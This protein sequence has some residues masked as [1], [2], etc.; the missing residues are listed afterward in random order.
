MDIKDDIKQAMKEKGITTIKELSVI[1]GISQACLYS[2]LNK[3]NT[4]MSRVTA[5]KLNSKLN[6]KLEIATKNNKKENNLIK[7]AMQKNG[8]ETVKEL[9]ILTGLS[10]D[11]LY[12]LT[13]NDNCSMNSKTAKRLN[14]VLHLDLT[15]IE[16]KNDNSVGYRIFKLRQKK[17]ISAER[18]SVLADISISTVR[19]LEINKNKPS[20]LTIKKIAK[21]F[22]MEEFELR[23]ILFNN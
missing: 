9:S 4:N 17:D 10:Q 16:R 8:I 12:K 1:T 21:A 6:L 23:K 22:D 14:E 13:T 18:L 5:A 15:G 19:A 7:D 3:E 20:T 11:N 2:V